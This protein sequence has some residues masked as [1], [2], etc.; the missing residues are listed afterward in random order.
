MK[1][2]ELVEVIWKDAYGDAPVKIRKDNFDPDKMRLV[3]SSSSASS[4]TAEAEN[5]AVEEAPVK[6]AKTPTRKK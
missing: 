1:T 5:S 6:P 4:P 2:F 3:G